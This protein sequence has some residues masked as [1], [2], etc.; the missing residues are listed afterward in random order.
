MNKLKSS[1]V[2]L[3]LSVL[4]V[5]ILIGSASATDEAGNETVSTSTGVDALSQEVD[6]V[7]DEVSAAEPTGD[8]VVNDT[9]KQ[10]EKLGA[11]NDEKDVLEAS[12]INVDTYNNLNNAIRN[13][14][15]SEI[16]IISNLNANKLIQFNHGNLVIDGNGYSINGM[17]NKFCIFNINGYSNITF[18]NISKNIIHR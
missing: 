2:M 9:S 6:S 8:L 18:K 12:S 11:S 15:V 17:N 16:N 1:K 4:L 13:T 7:D 5:F 3:V 14:G 10:D